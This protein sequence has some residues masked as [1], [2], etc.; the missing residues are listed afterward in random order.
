MRRFFIL[1]ILLAVAGAA[2]FYAEQWNFFAPGPPARR[3]IGT[4]VWIKAGERSAA[5][6]Q[7][8][9]HARVVRNATFFRLGVTA[10]RK[11]SDLKAGE[12][13]IPSAASMAD[14][15]GILIAGKSIQHKLTA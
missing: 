2:L 4:V 15:M 13:A 1:V 11:N 8:L 7:Q 6:A 14:V 5:I 9:E 3:G 10:R 12:Y